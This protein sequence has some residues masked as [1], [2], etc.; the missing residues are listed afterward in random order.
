MD[1]S[2]RLIRVCHTS[3]EPHEKPGH[4]SA[5]GLVTTNLVF[6]KANRGN[7][8]VELSELLPGALEHALVIALGTFVLALLLAVLDVPAILHFH[9]GNLVDLLGPA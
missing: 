4:V 1:D 3:S 5:A 6:T 7:S 9:A 8:A 2:A